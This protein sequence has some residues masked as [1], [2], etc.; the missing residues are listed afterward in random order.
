[1]NK[2][3]L[4]SQAPVSKESIERAC[5]IVRANLDNPSNEIKFKALEALDIRI[6]TTEERFLTIAGTLPVS[7]L[8]IESGQVKYNW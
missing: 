6:S 4:A 2:L 3:E 1:M 8:L 7:N 5:Q